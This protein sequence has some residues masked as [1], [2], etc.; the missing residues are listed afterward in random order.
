[1][2]FVTDTKIIADEACK[3]ARSFIVKS[4]TSL[5]T[6]K[7]NFSARNQLRSGIKKIRAEVRNSPTNHQFADNATYKFFLQ[8]EYTRKYSLGNCI[9]YTLLALE[10]VLNHADSE[11]RA[12]AFQINNGDHVFLVINRKPYSS[13][14]DPMRW[15]D[16]AYI[17]DPWANE[18]YPAHE[19]EEKLKNYECR[20]FV[21]SGCDLN[22]CWRFP[23]HP[24]HYKNSYLYVKNDDMRQLYYIMP[25]GK[26]EL[27][28]I[29]DYDLFEQKLSEITK[30]KDVNYI[31]LSKEQI[32]ELITDNG[33]H[34]FTEE[35][36]SYE[37]KLLP[38]TYFNRKLSPIDDFN[39]D[40]L[41]QKNPFADQIARK[42]N[43]HVQP[44]KNAI[45]RLIDKVEKMS[46]VIKNENGRK[47]LISQN[48]NSS[49]ELL[50]WV[51]EHLSQYDNVQYFNKFYFNGRTQW[52][53]DLKA[54]EEVCNK[55]LM[56]CSMLIEN[57]IQ[58]E[59]KSNVN[60]LGIFFSQNPS[61][62][63]IQ[64]SIAETKKEVT[65]IFNRA[66]KIN[67]R[68]IEPYY[69]EASSSQTLKN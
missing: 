14:S 25:N 63:K 2:G 40:N 69:E 28:N 34:I 21:I 54:S 50:S 53:D 55:A 3:Y 43:K 38:H 19:Y 41:R 65:E 29:N 47:G 11:V 67:W 66:A 5:E 13:L 1:M 45:N 61:F 58:N 30:A 60:Q 20:R 59:N 32:K 7:L 35:V 57:C 44:L 17:C 4:Y 26:E 12:E 24:K 68:K 15:G 39:T 22:L 18:V 10:Y 27:V 16:N 51:K 56:E 9:E 42:L 46:T 31:Q 23:E 33:G 52:L 6:N 36:K 8:N 64:Q 48:V 49:L 62:C 37:N